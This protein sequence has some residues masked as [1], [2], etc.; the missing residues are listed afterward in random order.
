[1]WALITRNVAECTLSLH[2]A[3]E[4]GSIHARLPDTGASGRRQDA[5]ETRR[6]ANPTIN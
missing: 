4:P 1:M 2:Q 3:P 6:N 5:G